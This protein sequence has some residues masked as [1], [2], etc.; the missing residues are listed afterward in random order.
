MQYVHLKDKVMIFAV[1]HDITKME[2]VGKTFMACSGLQV[3]LNYSSS[4]FVREITKIM[5]NE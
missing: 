1:K 3:C 2:T 5:H 4:S